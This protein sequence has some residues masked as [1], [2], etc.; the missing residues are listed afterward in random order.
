[1]NMA[2]EA[3]G[4]LSVKWDKARVFL[5]GPP[6]TKSPEK[7]AG[8]RMEQKRVSPLSKTLMVNRKRSTNANYSPEP[9]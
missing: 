2:F 5:D 8:V 6:P 4:S 7:I 1:M 3:S 9:G